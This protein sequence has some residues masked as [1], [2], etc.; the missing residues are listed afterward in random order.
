MPGGRKGRGGRRVGKVGTAYGNRSDLNGG[1]SPISTMKGQ[2]YGVAGAQEDAQR[3]VP[4]GRPEIA[5]PDPASLPPDRP[6]PGSLPG[7][8]ADSTNPDEDIMS[9]ARVGPG[10]GPEAFSFGQQDQREMDFAGR[11]LPAMAVTANGPT[12]SAAAR[13]LVRLLRAHMES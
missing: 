12:G 11:Y 5:M 4:M 9:G 2:P 10:P 8:F 7:L 6:R 3:A 13:R 1:P